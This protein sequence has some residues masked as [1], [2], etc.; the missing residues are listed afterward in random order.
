M[1]F[2]YF[3]ECLFLQ[4]ESKDSKVVPDLEHKLEYG[5]LKVDKWK[6]HLASIEITS[7]KQLELAGREDYEKVSK[8]AKQGWEKKA[9]RILFGVEKTAVAPSDELI[10]AVKEQHAELQK[11][12]APSLSIGDIPTTKPDAGMSSEFY[13]KFAGC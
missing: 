13:H 8:Y 7:V 1:T 11:V 6:E 4:E 10:K 3:Y 2:T 9:L 12:K 5:G